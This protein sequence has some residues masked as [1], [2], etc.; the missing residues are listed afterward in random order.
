MTV[1]EKNGK[2]YSRF[3]I[4]GERHHFLCP[5]ATTRKEAENMEAQFKYKVQQQQ[6]GVIPKEGKKRYKLKTLKNNFLKYSEQNRKVYKQDVGRLRI[7][8]VFFSDDRYADSIKRKNVEDFKAW[9]ISKNKSK[10]TVNMYIGIFR[11]MYNLAIKDELV[12][13]NPFLKE[14]E[15]KLEPTKIRYLSDEEQKKLINA[16]TDC[17]MPIILFALNTGLRKSNIIDLKWEDVDF[18]F[19]TIEITKNKGNKYIKLPMNPVVIEV[20]KSIKRTSE[21]VFINPITDRQWSTSSFSR[22]WNN[23]R[24]K[25][26]MSNLKFHELRH[27]FCTRLVKN[28]TPMPVVKELMT[29]SDVKT[30]MVYTHVDL[31]DMV[32]A[33]DGL[34]SYK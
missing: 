28:K 13:K 21:Y 8:S 17:F 1:R 10:K 33:V 26:E 27:T 2:W 6:N 34:C 32:N 7:A 11:V 5:G 30:T 31:F 12:S 20:L 18:N 4:N 16:S 23:I 14:T 15:F 24:N 29:H 19:N 9:L 3:Q 25:A 22:E